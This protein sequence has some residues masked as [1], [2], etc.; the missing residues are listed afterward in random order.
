MIDCPLFALSDDTFKNIN[1]KKEISIEIDE[2]SL[3]NPDYITNFK[4]SEGCSYICFDLDSYKI[5]E[6]EENKEKDYINCL[7]NIFNIIIDNENNIKFK[8]I[9]FKNFD[10]TKFEYVTGENYINFDEN[11]NIW[12]LNEEENNK[13]KQFENF[14]TKFR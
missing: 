14:D 12:V 3:L 9:K 10:I 5:N 8:K 6:D 1:N 2:N 4:V 13:K 7:E 11:S